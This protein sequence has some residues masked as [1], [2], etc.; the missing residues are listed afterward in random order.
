LRE[1]P[2]FQKRNRLN[3]SRYIPFLV[4]RQ[5]FDSSLFIG[6]DG[7]FHSTSSIFYSQHALSSHGVLF[8]F[9]YMDVTL[10]IADSHRQGGKI[11]LV[12][13]LIWGVSLCP[14][15]PFSLLSRIVLRIYFG[16]PTGSLF[17]GIYLSVT[18]LFA[19]EQWRLFFATLLPSHYCWATLHFI[20]SPF[21]GSYGASS[22]ISWF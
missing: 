7:G 9:L 6:A 17:L 22:A 10:C 4:T 11:D 19:M 12:F 1:F 5:L 16:L 13:C 21:I 3:I 20:V 18:F 8:L 15:I 14:S 2:A